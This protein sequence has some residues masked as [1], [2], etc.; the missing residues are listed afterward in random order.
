VEGG[1]LAAESLAMGKE[2]NNKNN[3]HNKR[4]I[5]HPSETTQEK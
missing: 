5:H 2:N 3:K 1:L 4:T